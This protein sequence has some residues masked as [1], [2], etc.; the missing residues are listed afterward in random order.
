MQRKLFPETVQIVSSNSVISIPYPD[1]EEAFSVQ[2][3]IPSVKEPHRN[4]DATFEVEND[5]SKN[6]GS[7]H[8][9]RCIA[10]ETLRWETSLPSPITAVAVSRCLVCA[11]CQNRSI[12]IFSHCGRRLIPAMIMDYPVS[13]LQCQESFMMV[14]TASGH[15]SV[16]NLQKKCVLINKESLATIFDEADLDI[17]QAS[18]K[19]N[20]CPVVSLSNNSVY[21][22]DTALGCWSSLA[23]DEDNLRLSADISSCME[24][25][26]PRGVLHSIQS[27]LKRISTWT[28]GLRLN[29]TKQQTNTISHLENQLLASLSLESASEYHFWLMTLTR[30]VVQCGDELR[31]RDLC[32]EFLGPVHQMSS[33]KKASSWES[34]VL[35][36][37]KRDLLK[38]M[39]PIIASN[40]RFQRI[41]T[42]FQE[43]LEL[44]GKR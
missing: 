17:T 7:L 37:Q 20:G 10:N 29:S 31:L 34:M 41:Y 15:L 24:G 35:T 22:F 21:T 14:I 23:S 32:K 27:P 6:N 19:S 5:L 26:I 11:A 39:L 30:Y 13:M 9:L 44:V 36:F 8:Y 42:E 40:L 38:D 1:A 2:A 33:D 4:I 28:K 25:I 43:Q 12:H 3:K 18:L 16:W